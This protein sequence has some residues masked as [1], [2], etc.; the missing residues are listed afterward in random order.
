MV[1]NLKT[2]LLKNE[3]EIVSSHK[4]TLQVHHEAIP[5]FCKAHSVPFAAIKDVLGAELD[6]LDCE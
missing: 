4:A 5:T 2:D 1:R 3:L 6:R